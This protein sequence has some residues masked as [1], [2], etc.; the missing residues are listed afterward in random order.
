MAVENFVLK[1][2]YRGKPHILEVRPWLQQYKAVYKVTVEKH[3]ITFEPDEEGDLRA[4]SDVHTT[5][6]HIDGGLL[7]E[8]AQRIA[9]HVNDQG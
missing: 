5:P 3:E 9:A 1:F 7:E 4:V 6:G 8:I 2:E